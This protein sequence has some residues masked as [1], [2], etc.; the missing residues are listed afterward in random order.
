[1]GTANTMQCLAEAVGMTLPFAATARAVSAERLRLGKASGEAIVRMVFKGETARSIMGPK[2]LENMLRVCMALGGSTNGVLHILA[3][4]R[5]LGLEKHIHIDK[6]DKFSRT[7]P[8]ISNVAPV[9]EYFLPDLHEDGGI[10]GLMAELKPLL[11][12]SAKGVDGRTLQHW[13]RL[14]APALKKARRSILSLKE[15]LLQHG[16]IAVLKGNLAPISSLA[17]MLNNTI[18][19]HRGPAR[20]FN[21]QEEAVAALKSRKVKDGEV[22][23][24]R[25]AGPR[26]APGMPDTYALLATVVG[27]GLEG[28]LAVVTDGRFSGFARGLGVCQVSP[29]A[30]VGGPL[31]LLKNGDMISIDLPGR[32]LNAEV[33]AREWKKRRAAWRLP[34]MKNAPGILGLFAVNAEQAHQGARLVAH[35]APW[36]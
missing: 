26:G 33:S 14:G 12:P 30:A 35:P 18:P 36:E 1:M 3:L 19:T 5:E 11:H 21:S 6:V 15:P 7:T 23:V 16:G 31:A 17:R 34:K 25:Y 13:T 8:C 20:C 32:S 4:A 28:K 27:M 10:P 22:I 9:G 2:N 29:E 24:V